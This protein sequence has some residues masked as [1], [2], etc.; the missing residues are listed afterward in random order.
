MVGQPVKI[1]PF[2]GGMNTYTGPSAIADN[3]AV[4]ITN[5]D[6]DLD[7]SLTSRPGLAII[8]AAT[9]E[10]GLSHIIGIYRT[11]LDVVYVIYAFAAE[12]NAY[13]TSTGAWTLITANACTA[14]VQY[15][16]KLWLVRKPLGVVQGGFK[17]DP[18]GGTVAVA[19]MPRG[20]S[21]CIY[22]ERMFIS[23]SR[24]GD[25]TSINRVKFS[26]AADPDTWGG[27]DYFDVAGGDGQD[28]AKIYV[29]DASIVIFKTDSTY[30]YAYET[31]PTKG[32]VQIVSATI[33]ANNNYCVVEYENNL[34]VMHEDNV[35]RISN[36]NWEH[37]NIKVPFEYVNIGAVGTAESSS[38]SLLGNR[39]IC[40]YFDNYY[41]IGMKTGA[42]TKWEFGVDR[43]PS[44]FISNPSISPLVGTADYY[45]G[46]YRTAT[47]KQYIFRDTYDTVEDF[48]IKL[49]TKSYDF[50]PSYTFKRLFWWG[51]D[52]LAKSVTTFKVSPIVYAV[53]ITWSQLIG[54]PFSTLGTWGRPLD[55][56]IDVT[57]SA[58]NSN[59]ASYRTFTKLL[60]G[61]RFRQVGFTLESTLDGTSETGPYRIFSLTAIVDS[62]QVVSKKVS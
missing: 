15:N 17:W 27:T 60:K 12:V 43:F 59:P 40:R 47:S 33:G 26:N 45:G 62:K 48:D 36:W 38:L 49:V 21:A 50:G 29:F 51:A 37:A 7:G 30:V 53:P 19:A 20:Y 5:L 35:Y 52:L 6:I 41:I 8:G 22:K 42:W 54:V 24:N 39:L 16:D 61:L 32:Q 34:F 2:V 11:S 57:D 28:I 14:A 13:N 31:A 3:E 25:E 46:S 58:S 23:A 1:G 4:E 9:P 55:V 56:D 44:E 10:P 18:V